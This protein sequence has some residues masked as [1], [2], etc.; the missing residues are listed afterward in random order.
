MKSET[1]VSKINFRLPKKSLPIPDGIPC[2]NTY[3]SARKKGGLSS[4][5][6]ARPPSEQRGSP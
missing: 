6:P 5:R 4:L 2:C 3:A 1:P